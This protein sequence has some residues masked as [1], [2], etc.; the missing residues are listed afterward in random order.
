[1]KESTL[2]GKLPY[3]GPV[4]IKDIARQIEL[5]GIDNG[6]TLSYDFILKAIGLFFGRILSNMVSKN[7][8]KVE[9]L[10]DFGMTEKEK[11]RLIIR[12]EARAK[13]NYFVRL[14]AI[15]RI[16]KRNA[17]INKMHYINVR[18][19]KTGLEPLTFDI[20]KRITKK[21]KLRKPNYNPIIKY[22]F[23]VLEDKDKS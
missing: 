14:R 4:G 3:D 6:I 11:K 21:R 13:N 15:K 19:A 9:G 10:G 22:T 20:Y 8:I 7:Y 5:D 12:D 2:A 23:D 1:M 16:N 17:E 18:R